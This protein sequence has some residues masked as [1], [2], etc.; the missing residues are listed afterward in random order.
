MTQSIEVYDKLTELIDDGKS[1]DIVYLDFRKAFD[2][3]PHERLLVKLKGYG[4]NGN[5]I[6]WVRFFF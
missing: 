2:S 3:I 5:V 4:I 6:G 1:I